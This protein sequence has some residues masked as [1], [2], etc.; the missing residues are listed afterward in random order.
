MPSRI[1]VSLQMQGLAVPERLGAFGQDVANFRT[2]R[3]LK[4]MGNAVRPYLARLSRARAI[5]AASRGRRYGGRR[6]FP[7]LGLP[8]TYKIGGSYKQSQTPS[9]RVSAPRTLF[10]LDEG[11]KNRDGTKTRPRR[12]TQR[13]MAVSRSAQLNAFT[14]RMS[15]EV[16]EAAG[17]AAVGSRKTLRQ[18]RNDSIKKARR[19]HRYR[20]NVPRR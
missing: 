4:A 13:A 3:A 10:W 12:I 15:R 19:E 7:P 9:A 18:A 16:E 6:R 20:T 17:E 11:K 5:S 2:E 1:G 8:S 14:R